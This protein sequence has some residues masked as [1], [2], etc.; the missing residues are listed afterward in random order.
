VEEIKEK[1]T[2]SSHPPRLSMGYASIEKPW[3]SF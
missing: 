2:K 3:H 1:V